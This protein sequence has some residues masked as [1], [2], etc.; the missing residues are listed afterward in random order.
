MTDSPD[1][2]AVSPNEAPDP[3]A[4]PD[5]VDRQRVRSRRRDV[6]RRRSTTRLPGHPPVGLVR[7]QTPAPVRRPARGAAR[8]PAVEPVDEGPTV[9]DATQ[10]LAP[11]FAAAVALTFDDLEPLRLA[12]THRSILHDWA[13]AG[14]GAIHLGRPAQSNERLEFL[15]DAM[16]GAIVA[17]EL[18]DRFPDADEGALTSDRVALVRSETLV[19]WARAIRL[20]DYMVLG[21]GERISDS[22]RDRILAGG[23]EALVGAI[24]VDQGLAT[25]RD[26]VGRFLS[27]EADSVDGQR[28]TESNPKGHLQEVLQDRYGTQPEYDVIEESGP[29]HDKV[30]TVEVRL[31][32]ESI[33]VGSGV[34]KRAAQQ[35]AARSG[36]LGLADLEGRRAPGGADDASP[37]GTS[38]PGPR[39]DGSVPAI[40]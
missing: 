37:A 36:L 26:F 29:D 33:G 32:G 38:G 25:A 13:A 18:Y 15:G 12:L 24:T 10:H 40:D 22:P 21:N 8:Q 28:R 1:S 27:D 34:S 39:A 4:D 30:F 11:E 14:L 23:F 7:D 6:S 19:R 16:L 2:R 31:N 20:G 9:L 35:D 5:T 3:I 17:E